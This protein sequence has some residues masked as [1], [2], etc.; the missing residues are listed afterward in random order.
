MARAVALRDASG[1]TSGG[2]LT[3]ATVPR[4]GEVA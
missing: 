2:S 1:P 4:W 3:Q